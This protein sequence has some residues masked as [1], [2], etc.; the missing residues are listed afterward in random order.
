MRSDMGK[1]TEKRKE[2][3]EELSE[4]A[5]CMAIELRN[6]LEIFLEGSSPTEGK[7]LNVA[8]PK[9][10]AISQV[11]DNLRVTHNVLKTAMELHFKIKNSIRE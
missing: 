9:M 3:L 10:D 11:A 1:A 7:D 8:I 4:V 2:T 6:S 5:K